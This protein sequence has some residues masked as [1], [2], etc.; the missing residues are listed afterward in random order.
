MDMY[1]LR[2]FNFLAPVLVLLE[3]EKKPWERN[4]E[5]IEKATWKQPQ[6]VGSLVD[7]S[8]FFAPIS[9]IEDAAMWRRSRCAYYAHNTRL[10]RVPQS[11]IK[12]PIVFIYVYNLEIKFVKYL[13][14]N[15]HFVS[16]A[17]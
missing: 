10:P 17:W 7:G 9:A 14:N 1:Y 2:S 5:P 6:L 4:G 11:A 15:F 13:I 8:N 3:E 12:S 16:S